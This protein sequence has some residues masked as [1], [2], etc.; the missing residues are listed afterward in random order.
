MDLFEKLLVSLLS[1]SLDDDDDESKPSLIT[2]FPLTPVLGMDHLHLIL[3]K[4][5][6]S[7]IPLMYTPK[8]G[9]LSNKYIHIF[10]PLVYVYNSYIQFNP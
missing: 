6:Y 1:H 8:Y 10:F 9:H 5:T 3:K 4:H 7:E 2:T